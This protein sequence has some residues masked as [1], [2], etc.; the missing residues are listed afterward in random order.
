MNSIELNDVIS[1][2]KIEHGNY[3]FKQISQGYINDTYLVSVE[4]FPTY[5]LQ[6]INSNV[7][8]DVEGLHKNIAQVLNKL[9]AEDYQKI[10]LFSTIK[11]SPYLLDDNNCW[12]ILNFVNNS[13]AHNFTSN[14]K[15]ASEAGRIIGKFHQLLT[16]EDSSNYTETVKNLNYLPFRIQEFEA[17][18]KNTSKDLKKKALHE[19]EF[20]LA[21][22]NLFDDFYSAN[23]PLRVCHNDT[24]LNNLLFD[25]NNNG[26]CLIDLDTLMPGYFHYDFGDA[27]RTV[28]SESNED[29][30]ELEKIQ[31]NLSLFERFAEGLLKSGLKLSSHEINF[32]PISCALMPFM[33]GLRALTDYLNGNIYYKVTYPDQNLDRCKSLFKF[34]SLALRKQKEI[35]EIIERSFSEKG[36]V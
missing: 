29:E 8:K 24:K 2:F 5:L 12:R 21:N 31:F 13:C 25:Q 35:K 33:H 7:F 19:I 36:T 32:L 20:G 28:V 4:G 18:L 23:L 16:N 6:R 30:T 15:L 11:E 9:K 27:I 3:S 22:F 14:E 34:A 10:E 17:A 26:L 1:K